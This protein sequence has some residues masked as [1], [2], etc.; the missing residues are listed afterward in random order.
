MLRL[1]QFGVEL[2]MIFTHYPTA[3]GCCCYVEI[4]LVGSCRGLKCSVGLCQLYIEWKLHNLDF[5]DKNENKHLNLREKDTTQF[6]PW[7]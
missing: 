5:Q 6:V 4:I 2:D 7:Q 1:M 3:W